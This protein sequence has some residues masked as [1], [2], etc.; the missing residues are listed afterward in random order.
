[1]W[2]SDIKAAATQLYASHSNLSTAVKEL[3]RELGITIFTRSNRGVTL[4]NDGT[5]LHANK[6]DSIFIDAGSGGGIG[7]AL[8]DSMEKAVVTEEKIIN[9]RFYHTIKEV[10]NGEGPHPI[11]T[12]KGWLHLAHGVRAVSYTHLTLPTKA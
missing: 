6:G 7:W 11:K 12:D 1:M 4:T 8:V 5:E 3:E 9:Q 2:S 10:K